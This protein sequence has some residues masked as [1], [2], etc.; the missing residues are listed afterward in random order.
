MSKKIKIKAKQYEPIPRPVKINWTQYMA[1][2]AGCGV[3]RVVYPSLLLNQ[4]HDREIKT[5]SMYTNRFSPHK[6]AYNGTSFVVFQ[7]SATEQQLKMIQ[8]MKSILPQL[9]I[10]YEIDDSLM[11]ISEYNFAS[12]FYKPLTSTI[13]TILKTVDGVIT[14][15]SH[16]RSKYI[17]YNKNI[18]V[19]ENHLP[20]FVWGDVEDNTKETDSPRIVYAGSFN[21]FNQHG[22]GGDMDKEFVSYILGT[23]YKYQ[24]VFVGGM[25]HELKGDSRIE[26]HP[27]KTVYELPKFLKSLN[28]DI[29]IA[30]LEDNTFNASKSNIKALEAVAL[31]LPLVCSN[32]EPYKNLTSPQDTTEGLINQI[33]MLCDDTDLR[34]KNWYSNY[35]TLKDQLFWEDNNNANVYHYMDQYLKLVGKRL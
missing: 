35:T 30:P 16:L 6:E 5:E 8:H 9:P 28:C 32:V 7:R 24:W 25:P 14:S 29:V 11:D 19:I 17:K 10:I 12:K 23:V 2:H 27:W 18:R 33:D 1:D 13:E 15:T 22:E 34:A 21:H 3:I 4:L 20:K 26:Y 31:G